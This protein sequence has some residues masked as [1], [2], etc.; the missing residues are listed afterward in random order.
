MIDSA[1]GSTENEPPAEQAPARPRWGGAR[2]RLLGRE[3][4]LWPL[5]V[6]AGLT[7]AVWSWPVLRDFDSLRLSNPGDSESFAFYLSWNV[8]ALTHGLDPFFTPNLYA[9][10]G[11]DLGNAISIPSVSIL[12]APVTA[13]F[14]GTA[15]Y[16]AAFLL[17]IFFGGAAVY[18]LARELFGSV[19]GATLAG[20][21]TVVSPYFTGHA[22]GHLNL[23]WVFGLPFLAYLVVRY[24]RER[25][26]RRWLV[27]LVALTVAFTIGASTE[28]FVTEFGFAVLALVVGLVFATSAVRGRLLGSLP[29]LA[30]G[31]FLGV[32]LASPVILAGLRSGIPE[33]VANPPALYP[34]DLTNVVAPTGLT[35]FG[36][37]FFKGLRAHWLGNEAENTAYVP[38]TMLIVVVAVLYLSRR[39]TTAG[40]AT[41]AGITFLL[42]LGPMLTIAGA[43]TVPLPWGLAEHLPGL[44][45][46]LPSRF[47]AFVF[48]ALALLVAHGWSARLIPR[49][50]IAGAVALSCVLTLPNLPVMMFGV[51]AS[52][53]AFVTN[54][55]LAGELH[56][57]ENVLI[58]PAGQWGPGMRWMDELDF[59]FDMPT[60]NGGGARAPKMLQE[61]IGHALFFQDLG[62]DYQREL[63]PYLH[64]VG[65]DTV[66][67]DGRHA[68]WKAVM[69]RVLPG[70]AEADDGAWVYHL[71]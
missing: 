58:L 63:L 26:R 21:L 44:N 17:A 20:A 5:A 47:S 28:L 41:F 62:Y 70:R 56:H 2:R 52:V 25:L 51:D 10:D 19:V 23:M 37:S 34:T 40:I 54:G 15:G 33:T 1:V 36:D 53:P 59:S 69:D 12:V 45:H 35:L 32:V 11:L 66:I 6:L 39:R 13:A 27:V 22:L 4:H 24:V 9:P 18:L 16:N 46:A 68:E 7:T 42:S 14:G 65:V 49:W 60:G 67:V 29:W 31:G 8:H 64:R 43:Q 50:F 57:G 55:D 30:L 71:P 61:P 3:G 38:V 48:M